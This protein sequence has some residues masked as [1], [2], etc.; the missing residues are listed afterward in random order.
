MPVI[1]FVLGA[2]PL[3][4]GYIQNWYMMTNMDSPVPYKLIAFS[5][6][7]IWGFIS[8]LLNKNGKKTKQIVIFLNLIAALDL[9][10]ILI[11]ELALHSYL[12]NHIGILT[13]MFYLPVL[14]LAFSLTS[15]LHQVFPAY[16]AGFLL[17]VGVSFIGCKLRE[18]WKNRL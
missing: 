5:F 16:I 12:N 8:F 14:N 17:M 6:L 10:L 3:A 15:W 11:Q 1:L 2:L 4:V 18:K 7:F 9:V 13:Q